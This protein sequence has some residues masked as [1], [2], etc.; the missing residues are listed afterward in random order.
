MKIF[1]KKKSIFFVF[2]YHFISFIDYVCVC[3]MIDIESL[4]HILESI[5]LIETLGRVFQHQD[6]ILHVIY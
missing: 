1:Q 3:L 5:S 2:L 4:K 6:A